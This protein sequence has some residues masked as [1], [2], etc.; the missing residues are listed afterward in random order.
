MKKM[1]R[2]LAIM[3]VIAMS[4]TAVPNTQLTA[5]AA[6]A[7]ASSIITGGE[8]TVTGTLTSNESYKIEVN[9]C[10]LTATVG[11]A[12]YKFRNGLT[13]TGMAVVAPDDL[14]HIFTLAGK[15]YVVDLRY[16]SFTTIDVWRNSSSWKYEAK[17]INTGYEVFGSSFI[18][19][20]LYFYE[21]VTINSTS[22]ERLVTRAEFETIVNPGS[23]TDPGNTD[24]SNT[25]PG[26]TNPGNTNPS[27]TTPSNTTPSNTSTIDGK[28]DFNVDFWSDKLINGQI[29]WDALTQMMG[30][31]KWTGQAES[32][33][34]STTYYFYD[35]NGRLVKEVTETIGTEVSAGKADSA[36]V[37]EQKG[38]ATVNVAEKTKGEVNG[39]GTITVV[40]QQPATNSAANS[41][42]SANASGAAVVVKKAKE[43]TTY[44]EKRSKKYVD[45][46]M[47]KG[48]KTTIVTRIKFDRKKGVVTHN[49]IKY[50]NVKDAHFTA[51]SRNIILLMKDG[52]YKIVPRKKVVSGNTYTTKTYKGYK[53]G[54]WKKIVCNNAGLAIKIN[55]SKKYTRGIQKA[56]GK[57]V[58]ENPDK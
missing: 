46:T 4:I 38:S 17:N 29:D 35:E 52:T 53:G 21:R 11:T 55:D 18:E 9:D 13:I 58:K 33:S 49:G 54:K 5:Y 42:S 24:P 2:F 28:F 1:T 31:Y 51:K 23:N 48:K 32:T 57:L 44:H 34:T 30:Q 43:V 45:L 22:R 3:M 27:N 41:G 36:Q 10:K 40:V 50:T 20:G 15:Y 12:T 39:T 47:T 37:S 16:G 56:E 8:G 25:D 7:S 6:T 26:N 19:G 14:L